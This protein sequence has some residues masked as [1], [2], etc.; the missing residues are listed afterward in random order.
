MFNFGFNHR[1]AMYIK[2]LESV[3]F[4][5]HNN[6][7]SSTV[8]ETCISIIAYNVQKCKSNVVLIR[9]VGLLQS[10]A[11]AI[12]PK[13]IS[14]EIPPFQRKVTNTAMDYS[15]IE[16]LH[17]PGDYFSL[18]P[19][20]EPDIALLIKLCRTYVK[21]QLLDVLLFINA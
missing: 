19:Y 2:A 10:Y 16:I 6:H 18:R 20:R 15:E 21:Y 7:M 17:H 13:Y 9:R 1:D 12:M 14:N 4:N 3:T 11:N 8:N 5:I